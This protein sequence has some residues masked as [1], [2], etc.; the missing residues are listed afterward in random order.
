MEFDNIFIIH[1]L[2]QCVC[3][4]TAIWLWYKNRH[5]WK[6]VKYKGKKWHIQWIM[7]YK[8]VFLYRTKNR[9]NELLLTKLGKDKTNKWTSVFGYKSTFGWVLKKNNTQTT[10]VLSNKNKKRGN[11]LDHP[12]FS[13]LSN[14]FLWKL[15]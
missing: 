7:R 3:F 10:I 9:Y 13:I 12:T 5:N 8:S 4:M 6:C 14:G 11:Y 2:Y 1:Q 15:E